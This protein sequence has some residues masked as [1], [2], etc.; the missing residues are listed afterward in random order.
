MNKNKSQTGKKA[1]DGIPK[2]ILVQNHLKRLNDYRYNIVTGN[3]EFRCK[4]CKNIEILGDREVC[5]LV[6]SLALNDLDY[7]IGYVRNLLKSDFI[8]AYDPFLAYFDSLPAWDGNTDFIQQLAETVETDN[9]PFWLVTFKKWIVALVACIL[10]EKIVNHT[11]IVFSGK[12]GIGKTTWVLNLVPKRLKN[13]VFSGTINPENKDA[14]IYLAECILINLDELENLNKSQLGSTKALI[15]KDRV[16]LRRPYGTIYES[17]PRRASFTGSVNNREFLSDTTGSRRFLCFE[18][19]RINYQHDIPIDGVY[20]Q[21]LALY[22]SGFK[23]HFDPSEIE[24]INQ[25]NEKFRI[26]SLEEE[27][28]FKFFE[29]CEKTEATD[30]L[31]CSEILQ[32]IF[33]Q[34]KNQIHNG[35]L[36]RLGKILIAHK[37]IKIKKAG[38]QVYCLKRQGQNTSGYQAEFSDS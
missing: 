17:L 6:R 32:I 1:A 14:L 8:E 12:Q 15:T 23:F 18:T 33:E 5:S 10:D 2:I 29:R 7:S 13:Y 19:T 37:F 21:A 20:A 35:S 31:S 16:R 34:N 4:T 24:E 25:N 3:I 36:Q 22:R 26:I 30:F 38:R 9:N 11:M 28:L 27:R